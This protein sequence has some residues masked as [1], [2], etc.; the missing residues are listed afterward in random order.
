MYLVSCFLL[1]LNVY[2][3]MYMQTTWT[4]T[5]KK[6][7]GGG[8]DHA[9]MFNCSPHLFT[10]QELKDITSDPPAGC[11]AGPETEGDRKQISFIHVPFTL[12]K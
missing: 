3:Y 9:D 6:Y 8:N 4:S 11:S 2:N 7:G 10:L 5:C 12:S 1:Q